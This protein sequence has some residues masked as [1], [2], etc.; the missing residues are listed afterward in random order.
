MLPGSHTFPKFI[1]SHSFS[2]IST[3]SSF[4][5]PLTFFHSRLKILINISL[6][7]LEKNLEKKNFKSVPPNLYQ[8]LYSCAL[9]VL[10]LIPIPIT[11]SQG[12]LTILWPSPESSLFSAGLHLFYHL[13]KS[14]WFHFLLS[15]PIIP[16]Q[17]SFHP[18]H[19]IATAHY[20]IFSHMPHVIKPCY[21]H[22]QNVSWIWQYSWTSRHPFAPSH[23]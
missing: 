13:K 5:K 15:S 17:P 8:H 4:P 10:L 6:K 20:W 9:L 11:L 23:Y 19:P 21:I 18:Y 1:Y 3:F 22:L 2:N 7:I 12:F 16:F 14:T